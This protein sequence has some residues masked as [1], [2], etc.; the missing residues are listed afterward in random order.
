MNKYELA[1]LGEDLACQ[2]LESK[3]YSIIRRNVKYRKGEIDIIARP[4]ATQGEPARQAKNQNNLIFIE[5][6]TRSNNKFGY[7]EEAFTWRKR[8]RLERAIFRYLLQTDYAGDWQVDLITLEIQDK[9]AKLRHY[10][11]VEL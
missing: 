1:K 4:P 11:G 3:G 9:K 2:H 7:P 10:Q 5:V 8:K 6:K